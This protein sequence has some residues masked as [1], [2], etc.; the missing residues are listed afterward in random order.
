MSRP[1]RCRL[2]RLWS[3]ITPRFPVVRECA[4]ALLLGAAQH[5]GAG[6][7]HNLLL[8]GDCGGAVALHEAAAGGH[9]EVMSLL[10]DQVRL[11]D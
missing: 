1:G 11:F 4:E 5:G 7:L 9:V 8:H 10:M 6:E 2:D 3:Y